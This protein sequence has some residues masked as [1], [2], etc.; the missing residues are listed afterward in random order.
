MSNIGD[1]IVKNKKAHK[2]TYRPKEYYSNPENYDLSVVLCSIASLDLLQFSFGA[3]ILEKEIRKDKN[4]FADRAVIW[5]SDMLK[6]FNYNKGIYTE[7]PVKKFDLI[8][9]SA[10]MALQTLNVVPFL[11]QSRIHPEKSKRDEIVIL[12]GNVSLFYKLIEDY[13]DVF[14]FG[15]GEKYIQR[16]L[17][18]KRNSKSKSDFI[19]MVRKEEGLKDVVYTGIEKNIQFAV[20]KD[21]STTVLDGNSF[22]SKP[23]NKVIEIARGCK[24]AC[25]FCLLAH[26]KHPY[27]C[28]KIQDLKPAINTF[29]KGTSIYPFAP[30]E[31]SYPYKKELIDEIAKAGCKPYSYNKRFD[32]FDKELDLGFLKTT[33]RIVFGLDG[34]SQR[35]RD[36]GNKGITPEQIWNGITASIDDKSISLIKLNIVFSYPEEKQDDWEEFRELIQEIS[37]YRKK[38]RKAFSED[39]VKIYQRVRN[40]EKIPEALFFQIA[41][42]PFVPEPGTPFEFMDIGY[43]ED[44]KERLEK[45]VNGEKEKYSFIKMEG[46]NGVASHKVEVI[47]NRAGRELKQPL[48]KW[49]QFNGYKVFSNGRSAKFISFIR[50]EGVEIQRYFNEIEKSNYSEI[51]FRLPEE[52]RKRIYNKAKEK[53]HGDYKC[54]DWSSYNK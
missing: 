48:K 22:I 15:D 33:S 12:G 49:F 45:L 1:Y 44:K 25:N 47:I 26:S 5:S 14:Y 3:D 38:A 40:G 23:V 16:L 8:L 19:E 11:L 9:I 51:K 18:L 32:T 30:D 42:T 53:L 43:S 28:N 2:F 7:K 17:D 34:I 39:G 54:T 36:F 52:K 50:S 13:V 31:A 4:V 21:I 24:Y 6:H 35:F 37:I 10:Y 41:P 27:R 29:K 46:L 20:N